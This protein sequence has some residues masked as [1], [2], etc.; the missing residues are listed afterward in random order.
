MIAVVKLRICPSTPMVVLTAWPAKSV[1]HDPFTF[2]IISPPR[3]FISGSL[4]CVFSAMSAANWLYRSGSPLTIE[5][6]CC[7]NML[8]NRPSN[9]TTM[10]RSPTRQVTDATARFHP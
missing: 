7:T 6:S 9:T 1:T 5:M 8:P 4:N 10:T 2:F 3:S